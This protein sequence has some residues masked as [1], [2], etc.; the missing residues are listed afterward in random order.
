MLGLHVPKIIAYLFERFVLFLYPSSYPIHSIQ[1]TSILEG[2]I[3]EL[4]AFA[5]Y[6][7]DS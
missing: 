7:R 3:W 5:S 6:V 1:E 4:I 2:V